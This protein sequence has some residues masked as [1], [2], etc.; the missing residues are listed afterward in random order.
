MYISS[1]MFKI[2]VYSLLV[3]FKTTLLYS[4]VVND[5]QVSGNDRVSKETVILFS[6]IKKG[7]DIG[8][9]E[10]NQSLKKLYETN[11]FED[12]KI[13]IDNKVVLI[14][15]K[16]LPVIQE[17]KINGI[18]RKATVAEIKELISLKE[19]NPFN[20]SSIKNDLNLI[21]NLFKQS[22]YYLVDA[23][24]KI[25]NNN[26]GTVNIIYD[27]DRGEK[28][29]ISKI[30]FIGDKKFKDRKLHSI[31]TSE[32]S[33][34]WKFISNKKY[35]NIEQINLDKRL[36][37]NFYLNK[38]YYNVVINDAY[39]SII[40]NQEFILTFNIDAGKKFFFGNLSLILPDDFDPN[41]FKDLNKTLLKLK[42]KKFSQNNIEL[43]LDEIDKIA[44]LENYE[45][46]DANVTETVDDDKI[47]FEFDIIETEK[48]YVKKINI[49]GNNITSEEFIRNQLIVDEGDPFNKILHNKSINELK[50][51]GIFGSVTSR[52]IDT[53]E[54]DQKTIDLIIEEKATGEISAAAGFGTDGSSISLGIA[55]NNFN[56]KGI[57]LVGDIAIGEDSIKGSIDYVHPNFAYSD[58]A[59]ITSLES[60]S[61]DKL[62]DFGYKSSL[63]RVSLGT[64]YQQYEDLY[65]SPSLSI[66]SESIETTSSA[67]TAYKKQEGSYFDALLNYRLSYDKTNSPFQPTEGFYST[68]FQ[69]LPIAS[70][71]LTIINGY[72][73]TFYN[74]LA[75]DLII[76]SGIY[77]KA[78]NTLEND[79]DVRV[80]KRLYAPQRRLRGFETGKVG[81]KDGDDFVGGNYVATANISSTIPFVLQTLE[82]ADLKVFFDMGNVWGV[83]YSNS[84]DESNKLRSSTGVALEILSPLGPLSFSIAE[85]IT[86]ASTDVT[87]SFR[88]QLGTTF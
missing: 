71:Q 58:R 34:F 13:S 42:G 67:S 73:I 84:I 41:K 17:I 63:N 76:S 4:E 40:N 64:S 33:K 38:G 29:T 56:G 22:G 75:D 53:D 23:K 52:I 59:L 5:I 54:K 78:V 37:K 57:K 20:Q 14:S 19:K 77:A 85:T 10:L 70:D 60:T 66:S 32:E 86:K 35:I 80:S 16:E 65:F 46:I 61:R 68:F 9:S 44:L 72:Q 43:I 6:E 30:E 81:P 7:D 88:F 47:N 82:N 50:S 8:S 83:D 74:E 55:E 69:E 15:V 51:K 87:E 28:A 36:L 27:I 11:F 26:D 21:L 12:V 1:L 45:F 31:I 39:S 79:K 49:L 3:I 25:E 48:V 24:V 18:K 62:K 2:L